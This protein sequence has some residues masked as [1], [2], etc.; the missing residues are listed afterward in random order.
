VGK[1]V[2]LEKWKAQKLARRVNMGEVTYKE[3]EKII[4]TYYNKSI[5]E[6]W[7]DMSPAPPDRDAS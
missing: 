5:E 1:L 4:T 2:D 7:D 6:L 3:W